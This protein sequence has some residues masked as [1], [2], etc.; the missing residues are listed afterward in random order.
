MIKKVFAFSLVLFTAVFAVKVFAQE[1]GVVISPDYAIDNIGADQDIDLGGFI[2]IEYESSPDTFEPEV[3]LALPQQSDVYDSFAPDFIAPSDDIVLPRL[4][5]EPTKIIILPSTE[6]E[7]N[8]GTAQNKII[9]ISDTTAAT[10][11]P[12]AEYLTKSHTII[13][14]PC[15]PTTGYTWSYAMNPG[16][17]VEEVASTYDSLTASGRLGSGKIFKYVF[18]ALKPGRTKLVF[19]YKRS[20]E[21]KAPEKEV[22]VIVNVAKDLTI[23]AERF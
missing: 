5:T 18:K 19:A 1:S 7:Q 4:K 23:T 20:W 3:P 11:V 22:V 2:I 15:N 14:L 8:T 12:T 16:G 9:I 17:I 10:F 13:E 21:N 6:I